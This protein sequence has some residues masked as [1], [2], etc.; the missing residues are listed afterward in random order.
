MIV[1]ISG[2]YRADTAWGVQQN[3]NRAMLAAAEVW[4]SGHV[5]MCPHGNTAHMDGVAHPSAF[6][7]GDLEILRRC[8]D[9][10]LMLDGWRDSEGSKIEHECASA[11]HLVKF[12]SME[13]FKEWISQHSPK[14]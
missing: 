2:P 11:F 6:I 10:I 13:Q 14:S 9:A 1:Y 7:T 8:C 4:R 3:I 5:A 12:Y